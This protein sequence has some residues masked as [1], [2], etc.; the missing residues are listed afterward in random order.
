MTR[1]YV[2]GIT[3][4]KNTL[5]LILLFLFNWIQCCSN[6]IVNIARSVELTR[7]NFDEYL[8]NNDKALVLY[9]V[10]WCHWCQKFLPKFDEI[11]EISGS[12]FDELN[13]DKTNQNQRLGFGKI[14]VNNKEN[15]ILMEKE[16]IFSF[17]TIKLHHSKQALS[18]E[19]S[20]DNNVRE[21]LRWLVDR[22]I[23]DI[24]LKNEDQVEFILNSLSRNETIV[25]FISAN[26]IYE[27]VYM[28]S[29]TEFKNII[30]I[31]INDTNLIVNSLIPKLNRIITNNYQ[32]QKYLIKFTN[33]LNLI[34]TKPNKPYIIL[35]RPTSLNNGIN[36]PDHTDLNDIESFH[37]EIGQ[38][39]N[40]L[41][42][43]IFSEVINNQNQNLI[44][45]F[46]NTRQFPIVSKWSPGLAGR[47]LSTGKPFLVAFIS[48]HILQNQS[49]LQQIENVMTDLAISY[50]WKFISFVSESQQFFEKRLLSTLGIDQ[51]PSLVYVTV[52]DTKSS[53]GIHTPLLKY[54]APEEIN[55]ILFNNISNNN[56]FIRTR[57]WI[58]NIL[59]QRIRP[60]LK[61][62]EPIP[63]TENTGPVR[64]LT[65]LTF[66][67]EV[68]NP[69]TDYLVDFYAPWCGHCRVLFPLYE[70]AARAIKQAG[71][72]HIKLG[73]I[74]ATANEVPGIF[75]RGYP[76]L[77]LY[78]A[79]KKSEP[80]IHHGG[81]S[82]PED[83]IKFL[84]ERVTFKFDLQKVYIALKNPSY[85]D[86]LPKR[87]G[88]L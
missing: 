18:E 60:H 36:Q 24:E 70:A 53:N 21:V 11:A 17:P 4:N 44:T 78:R 31:K 73:R 87:A 63:S 69:S 6:H 72:E 55:D 77:M 15:R 65:A 54:I 61:S 46:I 68:L 48:D 88:E 49:V 33:T 47:L 75:L 41:S 59:Q 12:L 85:I 82:S 13:G 80:L 37:A 67:D 9:Y 71:I 35:I 57:E 84:Y 19:Y 22:I 64:F 32:D 79:G 8:E 27:E 38:T 16:N 26:K 42:I 7:E 81:V 76:T 20:G 74:D 40:H 30:F 29:K 56:A 10:P 14:N 66:Q 23:S 39:K 28:K 43:H 58:D 51:V 50:Q 1:S 62:E 83:I 5:L 25:I 34:K 3:Y 52:E 86:E 45:D 2:N